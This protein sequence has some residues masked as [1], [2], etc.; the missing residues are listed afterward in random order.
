MNTE[1]YKLACLVETIA[2][3]MPHGDPSMRRFWSY[4]AEEAVKIQEAV[5]TPLDRPQNN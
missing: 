5:K 3:G 1:I 2:K 4:I